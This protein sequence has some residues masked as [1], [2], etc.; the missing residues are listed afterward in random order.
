MDHQ[1]I[2]PDTSEMRLVERKEIHEVLAAA[3]RALPEDDQDDTLL[4]QC[5]SALFAYYSNAPGARDDTHVDNDALVQQLADELL[6]TGTPPFQL[7]GNGAAELAASAA[8]AP[9]SDEPSMPPQREEPVDAMVD[10]GATSRHAPARKTILWSGDQHFVVAED[11]VVAIV[12]TD[13]QWERLR[14]GQV[15]P[16]ELPLTQHDSSTTLAFQTYRADEEGRATAAS[17]AS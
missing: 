15:R 10:P 9:G 5:L 14:F 16:D 17:D 1:T 8:P 7:D 13:E 11:G 4:S 12:V 6:P 3:L 2:T